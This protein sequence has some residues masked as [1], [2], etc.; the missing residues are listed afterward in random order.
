MR[1]LLSL[2]LSAFF[3]FHIFIGCSSPSETAEN[4]SVRYEKKT[5]KIINIEVVEREYISSSKINLIDKINFELDSKGKPQK[6]EKLS[7]Q[8]YDKNGYLTETVTYNADGTIQSRFS[9]EYNNRGVRTVTT[10]FN[11]AGLPINIFKYDYNEHGNKTKAYRYDL[12]ENLLEYYVY[13]YDNQSNVIEE[14]WFD[15]TGKNIFTIEHK[16]NGERK[17]QTRTYDERG[18]LLYKYIFKYDNAGNIIEELKY[19]SYNDQTGIIQYIY[20]YY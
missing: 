20:K 9:Y 3:S 15:A 14:I 12:N 8:K 5:E 19:D 6:G 7:T 10:R 17:S 4:E 1:Y 18:K 2:F 11:S 13:N 16:Y